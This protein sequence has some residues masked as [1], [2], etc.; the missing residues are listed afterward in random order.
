M[1]V[2][3]GNIASPKG[4]SANGVHCGLKRKKMDLGWLYS[5]VPATVA[6]V[7]TTNLVQAAPVKMMRPLVKQ[8]KLQ[9]MIVN[10]GNA[11]AC[12][13]QQG[14]KDAQ[15]MQKLVA[16]AL[17]IPQVFVGVASTGIIGKLL[18]MEKIEQGV[19]A[20]V[21]QEN[22]AEAFQ[23][24]ILTTDLIDK[25]IV[26]ETQIA[27]KLVTFAG[28]AKG[29]GMI[30]PNMATMLGFITTDLQIQADL[31]QELL[32]ELTETTFNQI[33][34][35]GDTSTNDMV[36][37]M[38][39][40]LANNQEITNKNEAYGQ[41]KEALAFVMTYLAKQIAKDGEGATKLIEVQVNQAKNS[42]DARMVAKS[43]V[44]SMLVKS[45]IF[46]KD[47]NWGRILCAIGYSGV[48]LDPEQ[49]TIHLATI[50]VFE[51]GRECVFSKEEMAKQLENETIVI[52]VNL[53]NGVES[54]IAW[55]CDLTYDYVKINALYHT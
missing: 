6:G 52:E 47:P 49:L 38:A 4:F 55:G 15:M 42:L 5:E 7:F 12:T 41:A 29:S 21:Q 51:N 8:G 14:L 31:L 33:T 39:N 20:L 50:P 2:I 27:G 18:P 16:E 24:A 46:G 43:V 9:A 48:S 3:E 11:N 45:A 17:E 1:Q 53:K 25:K 34:V 26:I 40:G 36:V 35:D 37:I 32:L 23:E 13:G 54:G 19:T 30:Q 10:S 44:G 28:C 22:G